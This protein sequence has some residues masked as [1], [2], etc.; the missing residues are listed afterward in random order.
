M[1]T[2]P[3]RKPTLNLTPEV[4]DRVW[5]MIKDGMT[6]AAIAATLGC[7]Q[8]RVSDLINGRIKHV[9]LMKTA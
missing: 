9:E 4:E 6:Q 3:G 8:P 5:R 7:S 2:L 1:N